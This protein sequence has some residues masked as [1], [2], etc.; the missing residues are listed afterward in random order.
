MLRTSLQAAAEQVTA[1]N[2]ALR[3]EF[4]HDI[5]GLRSEIQNTLGEAL[6]RINAKV[7]DIDQA[8]QRLETAGSGL[9]EKW[10][11][12]RQST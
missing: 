7:T 4:Q 11:S 3:S 9:L 10:T 12:S 1:G 8:Q 5:T 6:T 2:N